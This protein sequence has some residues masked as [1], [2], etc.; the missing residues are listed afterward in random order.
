MPVAFRERQH[1]PQNPK[2]WEMLVK[3]ARTRFHPYPSLPASKWIH[4]EYVRRGGTFV[5]SRK[6]DS[7]HK[8][9]RLTREGKKEQKE[10][11]KEEEKRRK[12]EGKNPKEGKKR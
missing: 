6:E 7:R 2:L 10:H 8:E 1:V 11:R 3:Q 4:R 12:I 9:G 5:M